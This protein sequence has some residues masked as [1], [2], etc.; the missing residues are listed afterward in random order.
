MRKK[1]MI[2]STLFLVLLSNRNYVN[3]VKIS[4]DTV[5]TENIKE[6]I[7]VI[8][9]CKITFKNEKD[10]HIG[11]I[12]NLTPGIEIKNGIKLTI[13]VASNSDINIY[14]GYYEKDENEYDCA[15]IHVP[16]DS[17]LIINSSSSGC[18]TVYPFGMGAGIGG[19]GVFIE[20][21]TDDIACIDAGSILIKRGNIVIKNPIMSQEYAVGAKIGGGGICNICDDVEYL[22]GGNLKEFKITGGNLT[23]FSESKVEQDGV[24][25]K[26]GG[27]GISN[28]NC[29]VTK[30]SGGNAEK[31]YIYGGSI[32]IHN[33]DEL[34]K[35]TGAIIGGGGIY[36]TAI[37]D[38]IVKGQLFLKE[39]KIWAKI[40]LLNNEPIYGDGNIYNNGVCINGGSQVQNIPKGIDEIYNVLVKSIINAGLI[41]SGI[42]LIWELVS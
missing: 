11:S 23:I 33:N 37:A 29:C 18:L 34:N 40:N 27:G 39:N 32:D 3:A 38:N 42:F 2:I 41:C 1:Y 10:I 17:T 28:Y 6:G 16:I 15:G 7:E 13:D 8:E 20:K 26:I 19:N 22:F 30:I 12:N 21:I 9:D 24:G 5:I 35:G 31:V 4:K 25:A 36:N 14:S